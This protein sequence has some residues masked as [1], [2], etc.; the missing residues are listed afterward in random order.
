[1][2]ITTTMMTT[3]VFINFTLLFTSGDVKRPKRANLQD[4]GGRKK[5]DL[6]CKF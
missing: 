1:M 6:L 5:R 4:A 2:T 3:E